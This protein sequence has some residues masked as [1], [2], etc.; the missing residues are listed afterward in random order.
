MESQTL[1]NLIEA[2]ACDVVSRDSSERTVDKNL[3]EVSRTISLTKDELVKV[4]FLGRQEAI[5]RAE[6]VIGPEAELLY[7][8]YYNPPPYEALR[9]RLE[10]LHFCK[11][12]LT[13]QGLA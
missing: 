5:A 7:P 11:N 10:T 3:G 13:W 2:K 1:R 9:Y 12:V 4:Y 8:T 6:G